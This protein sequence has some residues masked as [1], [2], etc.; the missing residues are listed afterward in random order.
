MPLINAPSSSIRAAVAPPTPCGI[1]EGVVYAMSTSG[2]PSSST[3][4][5][6]TAGAWQISLRPSSSRVTSTTQS[7]EDVKGRRHDAD[8]MRSDKEKLEAA[9]QQRCC[10]AT[11]LPDRLT[12]VSM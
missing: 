7:S 2:P 10:R 9:S 6:P 5:A 8:S 12:P 1:A 4:L 11:L 3:S